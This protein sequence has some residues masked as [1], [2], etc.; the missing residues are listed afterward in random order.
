MFSKPKLGLVLSGG[1]ARGLSH[2]GV[3]EIL[4]REGIKPSFIAGASMGAIIGA[5][6]SLNPDVKSLYKKALEFTS[7]PSLRNLGFEVFEK[8]EEGSL[9]RRLQNYFNDKIVFAEFLIKKSIIKEEKA[10]LPFSNIFQTKTF[11]DLKIP[12]A[13]VS[14]DLISGREIVL[15]E[16]K[17]KEAIYAS[18]AMP[19]I[20]P[21]LSKGNMLLVDGGVVSNAPIKVAKEMGAEVVLASVPMGGDGPSG[22]LE[23][24]FQVLLRCNQLVSKKLQDILLKRA[25]YIVYPY[26]PGLHWANFRKLDYCVKR[27]GEATLKSLPEIKR[28]TSRSYWFKKRF[29][30]LLVS[31]F[32]EIRILG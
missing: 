8:R 31:H 18:S 11:A 21:P 27:G 13:C 6:Y 7:D 24:A 12:F 32:R 29:L 30:S 14:L 25:D 20:F 3:L 26:L 23:K 5:L 2:I 10:F 28:I 19:G 15:K 22:S 1:A 16:G 4:E 17:L 9:L